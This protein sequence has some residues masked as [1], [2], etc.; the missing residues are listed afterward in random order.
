MKIINSMNVDKDNA[1]EPPYS[2]MWGVNDETTETKVMTMQRTII[3]PGGKN[4][5]HTH[6][7]DAVFYVNKGPKK[8]SSRRGISATRPRA[9]RTGRRTRARPS[10]QSSSP[11]TGTAPTRTRRARLSCSS[12]SPTLWM[13]SCNGSRNLGVLVRPA[14]K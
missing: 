3:P 14:R 2:I 5:M 13:E 10:P 11:P 8:S 6:T 4:Q 9:S 1:Y 7:C 12:V